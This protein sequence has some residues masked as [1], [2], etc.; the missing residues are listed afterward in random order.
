MAAP[1]A[2]GAPLLGQVAAPLSLLVFDQLRLA[3][4]F[5]Q[6][7]Q[8]PEHE[9]LAKAAPLVDAQRG[10]GMG[11]GSRKRRRPAGMLGKYFRLIVSLPSS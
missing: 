3:G 5:S 11:E 9:M 6:A 4:P 7:L 2:G 8:Q 1:V 10:D